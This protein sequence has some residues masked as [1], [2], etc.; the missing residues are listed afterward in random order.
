[1]K[2]SR[3]LTLTAC[4]TGSINAIA[5]GNPAATTQHNIKTVWVIVMENQN[6]SAIKGNKSAPY[7]S[8]TLLPQASHHPLF[9]RVV[10]QVLPQPALNFRHAHPLALAVVGDLV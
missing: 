4:V 3:M 10:V 8:H 5:A 6:W 2:F 9:R 1:M 7:I